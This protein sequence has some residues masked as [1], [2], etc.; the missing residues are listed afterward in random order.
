LLEQRKAKQPLSKETIRQKVSKIQIITKAMVEAA[1][2]EAKVVVVEAAGAP[3]R[4]PPLHWLDLT[5]IQAIIT[6]MISK[7][8]HM[9]NVTRCSKHVAQN[10]M[11][12]L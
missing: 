12:A 7:A 11:L 5:S 8:Y 9:T 4:A 3:H 1:V 10:E 6:K 2:V